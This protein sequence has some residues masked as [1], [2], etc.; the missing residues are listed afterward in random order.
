MGFRVHV[1]MGDPQAP[2]ARVKAVLAHHGLLDAGGR[3]RAEVQLVSMGD[4]FDWGRADE[5]AQATQDALELL[6]WLASHPP[7]QVVLLAGNHDLGR[8]CELEPFATDAD[9]EEALATAR[10]AYVDG[11]ALPAEEARFLARYPHVPDAECV[12][13]DFSCFSV[14]QRELVAE[15]L[16]SRRFRL[17]HEHRGLLLVHAGVTQPDLELVGDPAPTDAASAAAALN[18]FLDERV[19]AWRDGPLELAPLHLR[20]TAQAGLGGGILFQRPANPAT[21]ARFGES[22]RRRFDPRTLPSGF[23]QAIGHIRDKKCRELMAGWH[24]GPGGEDG[25]LRS[26]V[27]EGDAVHY[28]RGAVAGARLYFLDGGMNHLPGDALGRYELL[29]LETRAPFSPARS[30]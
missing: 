2:F 19:A 21:D 7:E 6:R 14:A 22:R 3:L 15:L 12:A 28:R 26:L 24:D 4:H 29:D 18:R 10:R 17:A 30:S 25:P 20:G 23:A 27:V 8:V 13:R 16:R 1:A 5:R 11:A 9:F